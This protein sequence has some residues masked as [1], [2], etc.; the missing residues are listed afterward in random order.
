MG[1]FFGSTLQ[2]SL[3]GC[4]DQMWAEGEPPIPRADC[5]RDY[6]GCFLPHGHYINM[7]DTRSQVVSCGFYEMPDGRWWMNQDFGR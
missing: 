6:Q 4:L 3:K 2:D 1:G 5:I 7:T